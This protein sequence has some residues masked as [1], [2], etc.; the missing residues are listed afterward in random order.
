[1]KNENCRGILSSR[2]TNT[3]F[4]LEKDK[5]YI[6]AAGGL[7][8]G[9]GLLMQS[10][11]LYITNGRIQNI[12]EGEPPL[13]HDCIRLDHP[14]L[15]LTP[16]FVDAHVHL[17]LDSG[18]GLTLEERV[19]Q[20]LS[21]GLAAVRDGGDKNSTVLRRR[22][23][24][25]SKI[26]ISS[27]GTAL[28][29]P[30]RY[31]SFIGRAVKTEKEIEEAIREMAANGADQIKVLAS[32]PV[33]LSEF[34][35][36]GPPQFNENEMAGIVELSQKAG[37]PV[38]AH[39]N[40]PEAVNIC[41]KAGVASIEHGYFMGRENLKLLTDSQ[42]AWIPTIEPL[43]VLLASKQDKARREILRRTIDDQVEQLALARKMGVRTVMG[44][45]AGSPGNDI[46]P[47][48]FREA[49]WWMKAGYSPGEVL[50][51]STHSAAELLGLE[52]RIGRLAPGK[53]AFLAGFN[54]DE[55]L[56][57]SLAGGPCFAASPEISRI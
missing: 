1:M 55:P 31:G 13:H 22:A 16:G 44:T 54:I 48:L 19:D 56:E 57:R 28:Y 3:P 18:A 12:G 29:S 8:S 5:K 34:G 14:E 46:G 10:A 4:K 2:A 39:A 32:G 27:S 30:G 9:D 40:G 35:R 36:V 47:S 33:S 53:F 42:A 23:E 52:N 37:L 24:F 11:W 17:D 50:A 45:D 26:F 43:A 6:V 38:M 20:A 7:W 21:W 51:A 15:L 49:G 41:L 25:S